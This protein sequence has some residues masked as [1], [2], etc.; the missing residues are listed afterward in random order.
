MT[1]IDWSDSGG[2]LGLLVDFVADELADCGDDAARRRFLTDLLAQLVALEGRLDQLSESEAVESL[3]ETLSAAD[4]E[5]V[6]DPVL[7]HVEDCIE[8]LQKLATALPPNRS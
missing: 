1:F 4:S 8:E 7:V 2:M 5:F 6:G 3:A